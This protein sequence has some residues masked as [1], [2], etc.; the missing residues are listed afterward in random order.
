MSLKNRCGDQIA[1]PTEHLLQAA[2][3]ELYAPP[4]LLSR[5]RIVFNSSLKLIS[6]YY[7]GRV[8]GGLQ[9]RGSKP[10]RVGIKITVGQDDWLRKEAIIKM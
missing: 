7:S 6:E 2:Q 1:R 8:V 9:L 10:V 5:G 4:R 3:H